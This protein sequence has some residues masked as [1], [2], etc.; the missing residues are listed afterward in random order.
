MG[1]SDPDDA[2]RGAIHTAV[3]AGLYDR[4]VRLIEVLKSTPSVAPVVD[5]AKRR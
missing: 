3:D 4:A 2:L 1:V 5:L